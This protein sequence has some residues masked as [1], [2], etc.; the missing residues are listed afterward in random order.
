VESKSREK[1]AG[2]ARMRQVRQDLL[3]LAKAFEHRLAEDG[4]NHLDLRQ[5]LKPN[6]RRRCDLQKLANASR[7]FLVAPRVPERSHV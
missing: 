3:L 1:Q 2:D 6:S 4:G 5:F 7:L